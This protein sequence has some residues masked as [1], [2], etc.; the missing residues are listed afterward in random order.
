[1]FYTDQTKVFHLYHRNPTSKDNGAPIDHNASDPS[2]PSEN[3]PIPI[4]NRPKGNN[5]LK[6]VDIC[7]YSYQKGTPSCSRVE[8]GQYQ[9]Y[10]G[11]TTHP[12]GPTAAI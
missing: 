8:T 1:M 11:T 12:A 9:Y 6:A 10:D 4:G 3:A 2:N 7:P 5:G